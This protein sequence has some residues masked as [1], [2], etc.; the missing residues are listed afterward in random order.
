MA[1]AMLIFLMADLRNLSAT[2]RI[3]TKFDCLSISSDECS[4]QRARDFIGY[5]QPNRP[6]DDTENNEGTGGVRA[7]HIM[8]VLLLEITRASDER[9]A[10]QGRTSQRPIPCFWIQM[11]RGTINTSVVQIYSR[12][13][14]YQPFSRGY[15][16]ML[17]EDV[18]RQIPLI[19]KSRMASRSTPSG[20]E[21]IRWISLESTGFWFWR[22]GRRRRKTL[23]SPLSLLGP[24][25]DSIRTIPLDK[26]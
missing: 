14:A 2:G 3:R 8:A 7:I 22:W 4:R 23:S 12:R 9:T 25:S 26:P 1:Q 21:P 18:V 16:S 6:P 13:M 11:T 10:R 19:S 20:G 24:R 5:P 17:A 15:H